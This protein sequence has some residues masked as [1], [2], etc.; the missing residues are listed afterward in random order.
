MQQVVFPSTK[1]RTQHMVIFRKAVEK[2][3]IM[4]IRFEKYKSKNRP[5]RND[6]AKQNTSLTSKQLNIQLTAVGKAYCDYLDISITK[7]G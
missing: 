7:N 2:K 6:E 3:K 5:G 4:L 1:H